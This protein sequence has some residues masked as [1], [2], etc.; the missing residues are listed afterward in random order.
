MVDLGEIVLQNKREITEAIID[1]LNK[2]IESYSALHAVKFRTV[3][4]L[5]LHFV[6][7]GSLPWWANNKTKFNQFLSRNDYE[8]DSKKSIYDGVTKNKFYFQRFFNAL[9]SKN[10]ARFFKEYLQN[11]YLFFSNGIL[12]FE[13]LLATI[14]GNIRSK[15]S[16]RIHY[17]LFTSLVSYH[18]KL[19]VGFS[20]VLKKVIEDFTI[21]W[22]TVQEVLALKSRGLKSFS[23]H[24]E[25][26]ENR[27]LSNQ[28]SFKSSLSSL[29]QIRM[30][31][32]HG[33]IN[34]FKNFGL[35]YLISEFTHL[36]NVDKKSLHV[37][38]LQLNI[39]DEPMKLYRVSK[40]VNLGNLHEYLKIYFE[41]SR[42]VFLRHTYSFVKFMELKGEIN[43]PSVFSFLHVIMKLKTL[44]PSTKKD[45]YKRLIHFDIKEL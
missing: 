28:L 38:F 36:L 12:F 13:K 8:E 18:N 4:G 20:L 42:S 41:A 19:D 24:L 22:N 11:N 15:D 9:N 26:D 5:I 3:E 40:L 29:A 23:E 10:K 6:R 45:F 31:I 35:P 1:K 7:H 25:F 39:D 14:L 32:E 43:S 37:L 30:F 2:E 33:I 21:E 17:E 34:E 44:S 16:A 27:F